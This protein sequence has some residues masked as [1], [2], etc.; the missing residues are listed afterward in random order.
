MTTKYIFRRRRKRVLYTEVLIVAVWL[1]FYTNRHYHIHPA[2]AMLIGIAGYTISVFLFYANK[3]FR[4]VFSI[5]FSLFWGLAAF[6]IGVTIEKTTDTT[7]WVFAFLGFSFSLLAH[8]EHFA[9]HKEA[10]R[11]EYEVQ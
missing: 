5:F 6:L 10:V 4:Y 9:F 1:G 2:I 11:C 7:A 8:K 3:F